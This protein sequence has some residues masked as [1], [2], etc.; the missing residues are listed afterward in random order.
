VVA[1]VGIGAVVTRET[2]LPLA[3]QGVGVKISGFDDGAELATA[4]HD[5]G[6]A[7]WSVRVAA[8]RCL[9]AAAL[10][11]AVAE[12]LERLLLDADTAVCQ[13]TADALLRRNDVPG[14]RLVLVALAAA[15]EPSCPEPTIADH[16]YGAVMGDPRW[17]SEQGQQEL[18]G[19]FEELLHDPSEA[20]R[21][22]ARRLHP[23][24]RTARQ[25]TASA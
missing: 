23:E 8:G 10:A 4:V 13:E 7:S 22:Q 18:I 11:P 2:T 19:Q 21:E 5:A 3:C 20:V 17:L 25:Y 6:A 16:L 12:T 9:A 1:R 24:H 15:A 14:L